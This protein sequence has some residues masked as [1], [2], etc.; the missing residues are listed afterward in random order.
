MGHAPPSRHPSPLA[1]GGILRAVCGVDYYSAKL[2]LTIILPTRI[3]AHKVNPTACSFLRPRS[4]KGVVA[5]A[6]AQ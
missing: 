1:E 3:D 6:K 4:K 5:I 2:G